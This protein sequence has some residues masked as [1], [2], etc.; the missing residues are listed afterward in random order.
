MA[1]AL[2]K[3]KKKDGERLYYRGLSAVTYTLREEI[4]RLKKVPRVTKAKDIKLKI[5]S[6]RS[7]V[8]ILTPGH[9]TSQ[10][11]YVHYIV[12]TPGAKSGKHG[13]MNEAV[14]YILDGKGHE[15][16]DGIRYDWEAGD[17]VV[18]HNACV[19]QH[20]NDD[21]NRPVRALIIK[22]KPLYLFMNLLME[23]DV[24]KSR[25]A[26]PGQENFKPTFLPE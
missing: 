4:K 24:E 2:V 25:G 26:I 22:S 7:G 6:Q 9:G 5:G 20:F 14:F 11:L 23:E 21:P 10:V 3:E 19:H 17:V 1:D 16:H 13:H 18:V 12:L 15:I 8:H